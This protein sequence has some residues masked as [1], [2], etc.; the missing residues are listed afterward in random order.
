MM[1]RRMSGGTYDD[2]GRFHLLERIGAGGMGEVFRAEMRGPDGFSRIVVVKRML[3]DFTA[4]PSGVAMFIDEAKLSA[5]LIHPNIVQVH[6]FGK[7]DKRYYLVME[8]VAGCDL[9]RLLTHLDEQQRKL[10]LGASVRIIAAL[11]NGLAYAHELRGT[12]GKPLGVV[13]RDVAPSN[14]LLGTRGEIKL[15][16]FGIAKTRDRLEHTRAGVIKGKY[17][18][19]SP[20]QASGREL[21][22][23]SDLFAV[24]VV[25]FKLLTGQRPFRG[26]TGEEV[27]TNIRHG[28][29][30]PPHTLD[31]A[32]AGELS[33]VLAR[34]LQVNPAD[35]FQS[36]REFRAAL[37][38]CAVETPRT[39]ILGSLVHEV[40][41]P[42][43]KH[44]RGDQPGHATLETTEELTKDSQGVASLQ[45]EPTEPEA[46]V[47]ARPGLAQAA[48]SRPSLPQWV[49]A[50]AVSSR[51]SIPS[52]QSSQSLQS[53]ETN[54]T[55]FVIRPKHLALG[56][57]ALVVLLGL[58]LLIAK[59]F[60]GSSDTSCVLRVAIRMYPAQQHWFEEHVFEPFGRAHDCKV[61][62][63]EFNATEELANILADGEAD[64]AKVDIEHAPVLVELGRLQRIVPLAERV[65]AKAFAELR[66]ALRPE[67][68]RIG[69]FHMTLGDDLYLLPRKLE[70]P[71][72][73][74]RRSAIAQAV[75]DAPAH[76]QALDTRLREIVGH[77]LPE[78][79]ALNPDPAKWTSW[80][81]VAAAWV[82]AHT[83]F[84]GRTEPRYALRA[85]ARVLKEAIAAGAPAKE[86]WHVSPA[87]VTLFYEYA[88]LRELDVLHP[89]T[90]T[91]IDYARV[92]EMLASGA[93]AAFIENQIDVGILVGNGEGMPTLIDDTNDWD[94]A[95]LP[96]IADL[97]RNERAPLNPESLSEVSGWGWG[98]P[99][100]SRQPEL[101]MRLILD[102]LS[103][104]NHAAE[105]ERFPIL[106][107]RN[108]ITPTWSVSKRV[109]EVGDAQLA[110]G[111]ARYVAWPTRP[112]KV[113]VLHD[114]IE[115]AFRDIVIERNYSGR[116]RV[117]DRGVIEDRLHAL[118][119]DL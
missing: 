18:Y 93:L 36:A 96:R 40:A 14:I 60:I 5:R 27:L 73:L 117:I 108:D 56:G 24:G 44:G 94:V 26:A 63:V 10:P 42:Y 59:R 20:E 69:T 13:H 107:V 52:S 81:L 25:L 86:P 110:D 37:L 83:P 15:T 98:V 19:M 91:V 55:T 80:D 28:R 7:V 114:R 70:T 53:L 21:D 87:L 109:N 104:E 79:F 3:P 39:D 32:L 34:A 4:E 2:F 49:S 90:Y 66:K 12:D 92:R 1:S 71:L 118:L 46:T 57:I 115:R 30:T 113:E 54:G 101:A 35:R 47:R 105:L 8:Y 23:R 16:D 48:E 75:R 82:W 106:R 89:E 97:Q 72:L 99:R 45:P 102:I 61:K 38:A 85:Q 67:A 29:Y 65:D 31:P 50:Q 119:D 76:K 111:K 74:Y 58:T 112:R 33:D 88:V 51:P 64:V 103:R 22:A 77:G 84:R 100:N 78:G 43:T 6:D 62:V 11:L 17:H 95:P 68:L 9:S 116:D 41:A